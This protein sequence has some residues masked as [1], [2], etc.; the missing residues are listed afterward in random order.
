RRVCGGREGWGWVGG[1]AGYAPNFLPLAVALEQL[2][3]HGSYQQHGSD[4]SAPADPSEGHHGSDE[5]AGG[6]AL[7]GFRRLE[8]PLQAERRQDEERQADRYCRRPED[9]ELHQLSQDAVLPGEKDVREGQVPDRLRDR[10]D[11]RFGRAGGR[12]SGRSGAF[13]VRPGQGG[14]LRSVSPIGVSLHGRL[15]PPVFFGLETESFH[16]ATIET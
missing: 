3:G 6:Y 13:Q 14:E 15:R 7:F 10:R 5:E 4:R 2:Q 11:Q 1:G 16:A 9:P 8:G 12:A